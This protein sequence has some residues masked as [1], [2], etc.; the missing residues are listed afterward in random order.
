MC[1]CYPTEKTGGTAYT[2]K[3]AVS[4]GIS[5]ENVLQKQKT[6]EKIHLFA[7]SC[8]VKYAT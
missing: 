7:S 4:K 5:I 8:F 1:V 6:G 2:V 3:Y